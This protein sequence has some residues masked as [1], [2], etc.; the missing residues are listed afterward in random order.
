MD[1]PSDSA[2]LR[3]YVEQHNQ[4]SFGTLVHRRVNLVYSVALRQCGGDA[5][6]AQDVTQKVFADLARKAAELSGRAVLSGWLYRSA[7]FAASDAVRVERRRRAREEASMQQMTNEPQAAVDWERLRP[8]IDEAMTELDD[9]DRDAIALRFFEDRGFADIG[10]ALRLTEDTAR[11]RVERALDKL[12]IVLRRR[13]VTSTA[14][15]LGVALANQVAT[16]APADL[17]ASISTV[18][19]A[20]FAAMSAKI[21]AGAAAGASGPSGAL[22]AT[23]CAVGV[24]VAAAYI[25]QN[26]TEKKLE[27]ELAP[28]RVEREAT[29]ELRTEN[30]RLVAALAE[31]ESL[32]NDDVEFARLSQRVVQLSE[33]RVQRQ[34]ATPDMH[35][36]SIATVRA[37][38]D[39][40]NRE[41]NQ[42]IAE[43]EAL[44]KRAAD[45]APAERASLAAEV[46]LKKAEFD[47]KRKAEKAF[48]RQARQAGL[49]PDMP[50]PASVT[51]VR[52]PGPESDIL[53]L[54]LTDSDC[55]AILSA[56]ENVTA[57]SYRRD[58]SLANVTGTVSLRL[59][60][61]TEGKA[62]SALLNALNRLQVRVEAD[63]SGT[64]IAKDDRRPGWLEPRKQ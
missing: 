32:K 9:S 30:Q 51:I 62:M 19:T 49:L 28:L 34:R 4:A 2:L 33:A 16:A 25:A 54:Q 35:V 63:S 26:R 61:C 24:I 55:N 11:K 14:E 20:E 45:A 40:M 13:G 47:A 6:L 42:L 15:A 10:A 39:Q 3:C 48:I 22:A 50:T 41:G 18:V 29:A 38:I 37:R 27:A 59:D 58:P 23:L 1:T 31:A 36:E 60:R 44:S 64:L 17:A 57:M 46:E 12:H 8:L 7:Q 43:Y 21:G 5:Q 53:S 52:M 56:L